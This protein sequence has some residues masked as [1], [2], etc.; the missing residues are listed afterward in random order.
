MSIQEE[1]NTNGLSLIQQYK[2]VT[3]INQD[4]LR[5]AKNIEDLINIKIET[6]DKPL[7]N[8]DNT[9]NFKQYD[10][11]QFRQKMPCMGDRQF[12]VNQAVL[13]KSS[14]KQRYSLEGNLEYAAGGFLRSG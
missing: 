11:L 14:Q 6:I 8:K 4:Q 9:Y 12:L 13:Q 10:P 5:Q 2:K 3:R 1:V 7:I